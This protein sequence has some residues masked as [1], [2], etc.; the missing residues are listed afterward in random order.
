MKRPVFEPT[1][2]GSQNRTAT[3][4]I[5]SA[6]PGAQREQTHDAR[7]VFQRQAQPER[8]RACGDDREDPRRLEPDDEDRSR[9]ICHPETERRGS[10]RQPPL[11]NG[12]EKAASE[13]HENEPVERGQS[14]HRHD[15]LQPHGAR[16]VRMTTSTSASAAFSCCRRESPPPWPTAAGGLAANHRRRRRSSPSFNAA[17]I[18]SASTAVLR[19]RITP[20]PRA[21]CLPRASRRF[22]LTRPRHHVVVRGCGSCDRN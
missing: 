8:D 11:T 13:Q 10:V 5:V 19:L 20:R 3:A 15:E 1:T 17:S 12:V 9:H 16:S 21:N 2:P 6:F 22:S 7:T 4:A 14:R 18:N